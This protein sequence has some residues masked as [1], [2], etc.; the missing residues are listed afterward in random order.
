MIKKI[1]LIAMLTIILIYFVHVSTN[2]EA[3]LRTST[4]DYL[5]KHGVFETSSHNLVTAI[6]LDYRLFDSIFEASILLI[7]VTGITFI[8][9]KDEDITK[10]NLHFNTNSESQILMTVSRILYPFLLMF[11]LYIIVHGHL[12]PGGGF[13]G[14][15]ILA[16]AAL[17]T[18]IF[19]PRAIRNVHALINAEKIIFLSLILVSSISIV[20]RGEVFTNFSPI[21][22]NLNRSVFLYLLNFLIGIK[23]ALGLVSIFLTFLKE[24]VD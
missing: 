4:K 18:Y 11:G 22:S 23:V 21:D 1:S 8:S 7:A 10:P 5:I 14:G 6:Y 3:L 15:T 16:T 2:L 12:S 24:G 19:E 17:I 9:I 20:T 13:Q